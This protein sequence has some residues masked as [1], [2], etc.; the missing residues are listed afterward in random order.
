MPAAPAKHKIKPSK[1]EVLEAKVQLASIEMEEKSTG[2]YYVNIYINFI[3]DEW[4]DTPVAT[5]SEYLKL[6]QQNPNSIHHVL[7]VFILLVQQKLLAFTENQQFIS[8]F[9]AEQLLKYAKQPANKLDY[10]ATVDSEPPELDSEQG[11]QY[12]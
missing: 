4:I 8:S 2:D 1:A 9:N 3:T 12:L 7:H 10:H 5:P 11:N 6:L